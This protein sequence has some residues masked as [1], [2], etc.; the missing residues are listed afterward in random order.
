MVYFITKRVTP[1]K[2]AKM[3]R[4]EYVRHG[5]YLLPAIRLSD[6]SDAPPLGRYG[7]MHKN[8][9]RAEKPTLYASLLLSECLYPLC[10]EVDEAAANRLATI[11]DH[12]AAHEIILSELV[13]AQ[14]KSGNGNIPF[15]VCFMQN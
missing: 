3:E 10:R 9:L 5:D 7:T 12:E 8:H 15:A 4:I 1:Q 6:P 13:Y 11:P 2:G 14:R